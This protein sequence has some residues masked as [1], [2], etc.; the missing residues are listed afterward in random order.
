MLFMSGEPK[1]L[2]EIFSLKYQEM[3]HPG[4]REDPISVSVAHF[5]REAYLSARQASN[6]SSNDSEARTAL[7][8]FVE[9]IWGKSEVP[10]ARRSLSGVGR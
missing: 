5:A 2:E 10:T 6:V 4:G 1:S 7:Y 9:K 8:S 3:T